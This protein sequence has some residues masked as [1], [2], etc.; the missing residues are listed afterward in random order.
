MADL[1]QQITPELRYE[2]TRVQQSDYAAISVDAD[3]PAVALAAQWAADVCALQEYLWG[4]AIIASPDHDAEF[5]K[6]NRF[7][8]AGLVHLSGAP[9]AADAA[10]VIRQARQIV[11]DQFADTRTLRDWEAMCGTLEHLDGVPVP[12]EA[13]WLAVRDEH[14]HTVDAAEVLRRRQDE[15][16]ELANDLLTERPAFGDREGHERVWLLDWT[17]FHAHLIAVALRCGDESLMSVDL[18][19]RVAR[20]KAANLAPLDLAAHEAAKSWRKVFQV[21]LGPM[22]SAQ[23]ERHLLHV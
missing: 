21:V 18:R 7:V 3:N 11:A 5:H 8:T 17:V 23:L 9:N 2:V 22:E 16:V 20:R 15:I 19:W 13:D 10:A 12:T 14:L 1:M 4:S 6:I